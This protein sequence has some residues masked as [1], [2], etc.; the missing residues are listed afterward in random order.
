MK[1][2]LKHIAIL[3]IAFLGIATLISMGSLHS[4]RN[5]N[6]Y[7]PSFLAK[8]VSEK[9][10]D[11]I[12]L[13][14]SV[15]LT[16]L[17]TKLIDSISNLNGINLSMD[18]TGMSSQYLM[19]QHFL[20]EGKKTKYCVLAPGIASLQNKESTFGDN[21][22]RFLMYVNRDYVY[23]Y[24]KNASPNSKAA[25]VSYITKWLPFVGVSYYNSEVFFP[26]LNALFQP[27]KRNRFDENGN[28]TYPKRNKVFKSKN[29]KKARITIEHPYLKKIETICSANN[30]QLIY[31]F[32]PMRKEMIE[33]TN[34]DFPIID[35]TGI[36]KDDS[37]FYDDIHVNYMGREKVSVMFAETFSQLVKDTI[38]YPN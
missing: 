14:S 23:E 37:F 1:R 5:S 21:D 35:N 30:I 10:F 31:Y 25:K 18:D 34:P 32:A 24:Y 29:S 16:T 6:F 7:K 8:G 22:Y 17:N 12:I 27:K 33:Y 26:S 11:Y 20:A 19:L 4:L 36:L 13:G 3:L 15:G 38:H 28:Y 9:K 2:F